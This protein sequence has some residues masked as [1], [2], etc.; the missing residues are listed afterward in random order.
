MLSRNEPRS[1]NLTDI[2]AEKKPNNTRF[3]SIGLPNWKEA[4]MENSRISRKTA[5]NRRNAKRSTGPRDTSSTRYNAIR[6]GLVAEGVTELDDTE[7]FRT[8]V[9]EVDT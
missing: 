7:D 1:T 6:H 5:A 9:D 8:I 2:A 3:K 4:E